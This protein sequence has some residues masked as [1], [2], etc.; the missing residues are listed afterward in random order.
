ML[1]LTLPL[2]GCLALAVPTPLPDFSDV[3]NREVLEGDAAGAGEQYA[4]IYQSPFQEPPAGVRRKA[5]FRAGICFEKIGQLEN[6]RHAYSWLVS[7]GGEGDVPVANLLATDLLAPADPLAAKAL[8]RL[9]VLRG[10]EAEA[11]VREAVKTRLESLRAT[12]VKLAARGAVLE[13]E[14]ASRREKVL[15]LEALRQRFEDQGATFS[16]AASAASGG[17]QGLGEKLIQAL[18]GQFSPEEEPRLEALRKPLANRFLRRGLAAGA[19]RDRRRAADD[20]EKCLALATEPTGAGEL[21]DWILN[22]ALE[23]SSLPGMAGRRLLEVHL[24]EWGG[25]QRELRAAIES[26]ERLAR[27]R[28]RPD[29]ALVDLFKARESLD[30]H[31]PA[32]REEAEIR[33]LEERGAQLLLL[34]GEGAASEEVLAEVWH[35]H[36]RGVDGILELATEL[37]DLAGEEIRLQS[38]LSVSGPAGLASLSRKE[39]KRLLTGAR[40]S[41]ARGA[42][43]EQ[44]ERSLW[45][46][47]TALGWLPQADPRL[48]IREEANTILQTLPEAR[49]ER[50]SRTGEAEKR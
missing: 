13:R 35:D 33:A 17:L 27:E 49:K 45:V 1:E 15:A 24:R 5:A 6:A 18:K 50:A 48:E 7:G 28:R 14:V 21:R 2:L 34:L 46:I 11:S 22:Q 41:L 8:V 31:P 40:E 47:V 29:L 36:R 44:L 19:A 16:F 43:E 37:V 26:A 4:R 20:L 38:P 12:V 10:V 23:S 3:W 39:F 42:D 9:R 25:A 30:W 32:V